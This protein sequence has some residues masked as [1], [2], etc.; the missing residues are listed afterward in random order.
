MNS[1][2]GLLAIRLAIGA[3]FWVHGTQKKA[4]RKAQPSEKMPAD[5]L[6]KMKILS[7]VEPLGAL[8]MFAGFFT[9]IAAVGLAVIMLGAI[10]MKRETWKVPFTAWDKTGWEFDLMI[11]AGCI[12]L[13]AMGPGY[14]SLDAFLGL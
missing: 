3:I 2:L 7:Y 8:A 9:K 12:A 14:W 1:S 6:S 13:V 4:M 10:Y 5:L 11:L